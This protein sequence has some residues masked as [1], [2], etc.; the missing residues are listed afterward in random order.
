MLIVHLKVALVPAAIPVIVVV[1][2]VLLVIVAAPACT[3]HN[4]VPVT[5]VLA[6]IVNVAVLH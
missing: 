5:G 4:P 1:G 2:L 3:V 6:A